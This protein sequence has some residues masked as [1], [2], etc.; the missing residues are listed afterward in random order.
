MS[1]PDR[2][3]ANGRLSEAALDAFAYMGL[4]WPTKEDAGV[5]ARAL[6]LSSCFAADELTRN[7][8]KLYG[9]FVVIAQDTPDGAQRAHEAAQRCVTLGIE[10]VRLYTLDRFGSVHPTMREWC[11]H[12]DL[13]KTF[14][15]VHAGKYADFVPFATEPSQVSPAFSEDPRPIAADLLPVPPLEPEMIPGPF[16]NW[17]KDI[18]HRGSFPIEYGAAAALVGI[19]GLV[20]RRVAIRPKRHDVWTVIPNLWGAAVGPPGFQKTP[21]V[22]EALHPLIR[23]AK[24]AIERHKADEA[25]WVQMQVIKKAQKEKAKRELQKLIGDD[26]SPEE[27]DPLAYQIAADDEETRPKERRYL[28]N[29]STIEKLAELLAANPLGITVFRDE[30][31]GLL[32]TLKRQGHE[33]DRSFYLESWDGWKSY[34]VDR[35]SRGTLHIPHVCLSIF[36][37]VQPGPLARYLRAAIS[38]DEDDGFM[39]RFQVLVYPDTDGK[40]ENIDRYPDTEAKTQAYDVFEAIE[41]IDPVAMGCA[42]DEDR[43]IPYVSFAPD[44]QCFF[45][46]WRQELEDKLRSGALSHIMASH[47]A[48]YRSLMPSLA[49]IFHLIEQCHGFRLEPVSL[50]S[51]MCA[52]AWC[53]FL[54]AHAKRIYQGALDGDPSEAIRLAERIWDSLPNPFTI[55]DVQRKGWSGLTGNEEIRRAIG[56]LEDRGWVAMVEIPTTSKGG[57]PTEQFWVHPKLLGSNKKVQA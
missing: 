54:E 56:L 14:E 30:L 53:E 7:A 57:R 5:C 45:D 42:L 6:D 50:R 8:G 25:K 31:T 13:V 12:L 11:E 35:I 21:A 29:D 2:Q 17:L 20:G 40:F 51:A 46:E 55:R 22:Q 15:M 36:G 19:S 52:A 27:W 4:V 23:L 37:T 3:A 28:I 47:L 38:G 18:A 41:L 32:R 16:R 49:L 1:G 43:D 24:A 48:K 10:N 34:S 9:P 39:P 26:E 44:A 33:S